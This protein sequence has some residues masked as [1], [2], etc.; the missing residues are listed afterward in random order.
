MKTIDG[1]EFWKRIDEINPF[2][3]VKKLIDTCHLDYNTIKKQRSDLR[4]PKVDTI[5]CFSKTL[6]TSMEFLLTGETTQDIKKYPARIEK[7]ADKLSKISEIHLLSVENIIEAI[8]EE[9][10]EVSNKAQIS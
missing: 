8:P 9:E 1:Y 5:L 3:T 4:V 2:S 6:N 7:L 10:N